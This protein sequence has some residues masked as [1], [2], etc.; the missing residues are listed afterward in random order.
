MEPRRCDSDWRAQ[1]ITH[2]F[3]Y[4]TDIQPIWN[5]F[6]ANCHVAHG[7]APLAG[8]DLDPP[9]SYFNIVD[10]PDA[11]LSILHVAPGN[12]ADSL[13]W[14]K[15]NCAT[16]GPDPGDA[17]MPLA[18]PPLSPA[19]RARLYDWIAAGAP[20]TLDRVFGSGMEER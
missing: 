3:N 1:P 15:V 12:P 5:Q 6:C 19:V 7:G 11:S 20:M 2:T 16:P 10:A 14:R 9:F 18:R 8:L 17:R 13:I 4:N